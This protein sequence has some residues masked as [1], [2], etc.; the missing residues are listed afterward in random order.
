MVSEEKISSLKKEYEQLKE[1][2]YDPA[3]MS[4]RRYYS[5]ISRRFKELEEILSCW[6]EI[7]ELKK[8][9][10]ENKELIKQEKDEELIALAREEIEEAEEK[11]NEKS[12]YLKNLLIP[13]DPN[14]EK[15]VIV[16]IRA[17]TGGEE[18]AL[19]VADLYRMY[20]Y[21]AEKKGWKLNVISSNPTG[22]GGFK[23]I[24]FSLSGENVYGDMRFESG[25]HRVQRVPE[26][27]SQGRVHTSAISVAVLPE[28]DDVDVEINEKDLKI[29]VYRSSGHGG[30]SVNT[31]DSAV[32][33]T[34]LPTGLVVTCQDEKSQLKNKNKALKVLRS[35]LLDLE[36]AK[37][38]AE[39]AQ[40]R[41]S[42]VGTGDRSAKI[43]TYNFPQSRVTDHRIN[44]TSYKLNDI[45]AGEL[46]EFIEALKL[47][48][49][50]E[51]VEN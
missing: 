30:Q 20:S 3:K 26:T 8:N 42:Q 19:F 22:V 27:E 39:I 49:R 48:Y 7:N 28:A 18:A 21:Y 15:D 45:L 24:I 35:R 2:I 5:K 37:Q 36:I 29:D 50:N 38:E 9:I 31:T 10:A 51:K 16:E 41:R 12:E 11:L 17:G 33:I 14:D 23:E 13:K 25:V 6:N 32:R 1:E 34:H 40:S 4:D 43:R 44:L 46:D 47:A